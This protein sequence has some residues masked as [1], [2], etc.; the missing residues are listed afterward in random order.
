[1]R[2]RQFV[3]LIGGA[4]AAPRA[5]AQAL[6]KVRRIGSV[7]ILSRKQLEDLMSAFEAGLR[8]HG[9]VNGKNLVIE[10][11]YADGKV[12]QV[13]ALAREL[14]QSGVELIMTGTNPGT[15][16]ALDATSRVPIVAALGSNLVETGFAASLARPGGRV[17]G[18]LWILGVELYGKR[19]EILKEAVPKAS[20]VAILWDPA[21]ENSADFRPAMERLEAVLKLNPVWV[22]VAPSDD[23]DSLVARA[24]RE[25]ADSMFIVGGA[26]LYGLR[27]RLIELAALRRLPTIYDNPQYVDAGGLLSHSPSLTGAFRESAKYVDKI[28]K[29]AMPGDLPIER[30]S[31]FETVVNLKT[32]RELGLTI[33]QS[34]LLRADRVIE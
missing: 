1:M 22:V 19:L 5:F 32:A 15:R 33:S 20:R 23:A 12:D 30:P 29:G 26:K 6:G 25:R 4:L 34:V 16:A 9:W 8:D 17:T 7:Q 21:F 10:Y 11:R 2:R 18:L 24:V 14:E 27:T 13:P 3:G 31:K 28:L